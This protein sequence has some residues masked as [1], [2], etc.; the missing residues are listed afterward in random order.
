MAVLACD[1]VLVRFGSLAA[2]NRVGFTLEDSEILGVIGP[3]GAGKTTLF[4]TIMGVRKPDAGRIRFLGKDIT[5]WKPHRI[6][7]LGL[8]KASQIMKPFSSLTVFENVL[9]GAMHGGG[10]NLRQARIRTDELLDF[11]NLSEYAA[12]PAGKVF[13][14]ARRRLELARALACGARVLLLDETMAGLNPSETETAVTLL[15]RL[16]ASGVSL[17]VVEHNMHAIMDISDRIL[18]L[19]Y[20]VKIAEGAPERV[21]NDPEVIRAYL[22][23]RISPSLREDDRD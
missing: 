17:I 21:G 14:A 19:N 8:A 22:G 23:E 12:R 15:R 16:R 9:V 10:L 2:V 5:G 7:R 18:V 11:V 1:Q 3:N 20:G 6:C 13:V 4:D